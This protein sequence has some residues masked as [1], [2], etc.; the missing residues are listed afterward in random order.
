MIPQA[1]AAPAALSLLKRSNRFESRRAEKQHLHT[2]SELGELS[3]SNS[4]TKKN[5]VIINLTQPDNR[6]C[7]NA[8]GGTWNRKPG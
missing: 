8:A 5:R 6:S 2:R 3:W 7:P 4:N 1:I